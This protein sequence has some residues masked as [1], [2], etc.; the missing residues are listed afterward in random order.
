[1]LRVQLH[2]GDTFHTGVLEDLA[3]R[4]AV[5]AT[6]HRHPARRAI[7]GHGGVHQGLVVAVFVALGKLQVAIEEQLVPGAPVVTT[8]RW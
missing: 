7:G 6:E 3:H 8:M 2:Q 5:T 1:M 4:H